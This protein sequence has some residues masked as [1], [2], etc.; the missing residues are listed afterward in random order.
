MPPKQAEVPKTVPEEAQVRQATIVASTFANVEL[1]NAKQTLAQYVQLYHS[2]K[3][4]NERLNADLISHDKDSMNVVDFLRKELEKMHNDMKELH[5][6]SEQEMEKAMA[7]FAEERKMLKNDISEKE[8]VIAEH[9]STIQTL[10]ADLD[11]LAAFKRERQDMHLELQHFKDEQQKAI[12]T[13][14]AEIAK[15]RFLSL[16]E[17]VRLKA[18]ER[19]MVEKFDQAVND[20]AMTLLDSKTKEIHSENRV[21]L[22]DKIMLEREL[23]EIGTQNKQLLQQVDNQKRDVAL[24]QA[25]DGEHIK[26]SVQQQREIKE[27]REKE[28]KLEHALQAAVEEYETRIGTMEA[29][30][31][32][33]RERLEAVRADALK[34]AQLKHTELVRVRQLS[35]VIVKQRSDLELFFNEA[36]EYVRE[37]ISKEKLAQKASKKAIP[38]RIKEARPQ[39][40]KASTRVAG[41][42][43][44]P[45]SQRPSRSTTHA[46]FRDGKNF[47]NVDAPKSAGSLPPIQPVTPSNVAV[48]ETTTATATPFVDDAAPDV[49]DSR[50]SGAVPATPSRVDISELSWTDKER[51]LRIL[52]SKIN[53]TQ[54]NKNV[55]RGNNMLATDAGHVDLIEGMPSNEND[56]TFVTQQP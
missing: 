29:E 17:K 50:P 49:A 26:K 5:K 15:L 45:S 21:L 54:R 19:S 25:G 16:E 36:L 22:N 6:K 30:H 4:Q 46:F 35:R 10:H 37:Q 2:V 8:R 41:A 38:L 39:A 18:E 40:P 32:Q 1:Q 51:V 23:E 12:T 44:G 11:A 55:R 20:R 9:A 13:Y 7:Q 48:S 24:S 47:E 33:E 34:E 43:E 14:E 52:F 56:A 27:L 53:S 3:E 28:K 31:K 42:P